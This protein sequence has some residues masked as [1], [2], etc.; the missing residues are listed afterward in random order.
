MRAW[1]KWWRGLRDSID[2]WGLGDW[3]TELTHLA[4]VIRIR[5]A[6]ARRRVIN[7]NLARP[8]EAPSLS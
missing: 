7:A 8:A 2:E 1:G 6:R 4:F 3:E 5:L